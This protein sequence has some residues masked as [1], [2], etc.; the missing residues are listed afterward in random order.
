RDAEL[1]AFYAELFE[2]EAKHYR[3]LFDLAVS[4]RKSEPDVR[5]RLGEILEIEASVV[6]ALAGE[7]TM[8]G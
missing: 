2:A 1:A 5:K 3:V 7:P 8:H 4:V 6:R